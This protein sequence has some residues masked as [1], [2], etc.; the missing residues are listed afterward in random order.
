MLASKASWGKEKEKKKKKQKKKKKNKKKKKKK[1]KTK[2]KKIKKKK[3]KKKKQKKKKKK[4][5]NKPGKRSRV[6]KPEAT[7]WWARASFKLARRA[8]AAK[9][10]RVG[11]AE[12]HQT[13][14]YHRCRPPT[15]CSSI[16][17][18]VRLPQVNCESEKVKKVE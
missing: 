7:T 9:G 1:T 13:C 15:S 3:K 14:H 5:K 8:L 17:N 2:T 4:N 16:A 10:S 12:G 11:E 6:G 18:A